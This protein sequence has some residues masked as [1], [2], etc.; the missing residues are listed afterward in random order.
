MTTLSLE[1]AEAGAEVLLL[2]GGEAAARV[3][4]RVAEEFEAQ[5][6]A[7]TPCNPPLQ[8]YV[9]WPATVCVITC[10]RMCNRL[11]PH[12]RQPAAACTV[13][14]LQLSRVRLDSL[15]L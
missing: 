12:V 6:P 10:N 7:T 9:P 3:E 15:T 8:P 5:Y 1:I 14:E 2:F 11:H 13:G 4:H